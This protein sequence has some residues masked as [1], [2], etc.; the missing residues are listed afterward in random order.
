VRSTPFASW[1]LAALTLLFAACDPDNSVSVPDGGSID[2]GAADATP[3][4]CG[5]GVVSGDEA[6]EPS[7]SACCNSTCD[8]YLG[9]GEVC[10]AAVGGCD[11][12]E[13]CTGSGPDCPADV[14]L[15]SIARCRDASGACDLEEY[16]DGTSGVCPTDAV[17]SNSTVCRASAGA[18]DVEE[19]C[20]GTSKAC[21]SDALATSGVECRA[22]A[23]DCDVAETCTGVDADCPVDGFAASTVECRAAPGLCDVAENCT[24][25]GPDCPADVVLPVIARCRTAAGVC[26]IEEFCDGANADCPTDEVA[27]SSVTCRTAAGGCDVAETCDGVG[28]DCPVDGFVSGGVECRPANP[29]GCDIAETCTGTGPDC[30]SDAFEPATTVCRASAD[31]RCDVAEHCTGSGAG[32]PPDQTINEGQA[33]SLLVGPAGTCDSG[34]CCPSN[35]LNEGN[36]CL[37]NGLESDDLVFVT[38]GQYPGNLGDIASYDAICNAE[39][40]D[41]NLGGT[42][43]AFM[44]DSSQDAGDVIGVGPYYNIFGVVIAASKID[45]LS[46]LSLQDAIA[47][48]YT[49]IPT[50][51]WAWTGTA[52]DGTATGFDCSDWSDGGAAGTA[53][54]TDLLTS[55]EWIRGTDAGNCATSEHIYCFK[56]DCPGEPAVDFQADANHC[57]SCDNA[58]EP[59]GS[60]IDGACCPPGVDLMTDNDN[61]GSCGNACAGGTTCERGICF[62]DGALHV[63]VDT[64][65]D[66]LAVYGSV[67]AVDAKCQLAA[68][69]ATP[70]IPGTYVAWLSDDGNGINAKDRIMDATY[71]NTDGNVVATNLADL[72]DS[73]LGAPITAT[74][75]GLAGDPVWTGTASDGTSIAPAMGSNDCDGWSSTAETGIYGDPTATD[76]TW[77]NAGGDVCTSAYAVYCFEVVP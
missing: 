2:G 65:P 67:A 1:L 69:N 53:G 29:A 33:C 3:A 20:D 34:L 45:L 59:G 9:A 44:S 7:L 4:S 18:C 19:T 5:D 68:D 28:T 37:V 26:D 48:P 6:C 31:D 60:C 74:Y 49:T 21:P 17:A 66:I 23:G 55:P 14:V 13:T 40:A 76:G 70:A 36:G 54:R 12:A 25:T 43:R 57:G 38:Y 47:T 77:T 30:P 10:R 52:G 61:C 15:P 73:S 50:L 11:L 64:V 75:G 41:V 32:C 46:P 8:G 22:A 24:G 27:T 63:F 51:P 58:C 42:Y 16:C 56:E 39:A 71:A 35:L 72:L 62:P